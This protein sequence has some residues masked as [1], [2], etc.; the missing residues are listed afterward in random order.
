MYSNEPSTTAARRSRP[1]KL[2]SVTL[3]GAALIGLFPVHPPASPPP[4]R[5]S[6]TFAD[7]SPGGIHPRAI[8]PRYGAVDSG[9]AI[10]DDEDPAVAKLDPDLAC[11]LRKAAAEAADDGIELS[12]N[13]GWRSRSY[14]D[15]LLREAVAKY[16]SKEAAARWVATADTSPHVSGDAVDIGNSRATA[17]LA[18]HGARYGLCQIYRNEPWH[19]E[20]RPK[21][22]SRGCPPKYA[23][24]TH[25][26]RMEGP[27]AHRSRAGRPRRDRAGRNSERSPNR[28]A[29]PAP[30]LD[31]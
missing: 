27:A 2:T 12:V 31:P 13:S 18:E 22:V 6:P 1:I 11:A 15:Q 5:T 23:D 29:L 9:A 14:Q 24:P 8:E 19:Y 26:P 30:K 16:G 4:A 21:A 7:T 17:W 20:L 3:V 25:D 10:F 28:P